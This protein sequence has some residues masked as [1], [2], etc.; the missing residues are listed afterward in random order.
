VRAGPQTFSTALTDEVS[1]LSSFVQ[2]H[3]VIP[4][5]QKAKR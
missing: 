3:V 1:H 2:P 5:G 4:N